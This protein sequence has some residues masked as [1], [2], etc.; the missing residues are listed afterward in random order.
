MLTKGVGHHGNSIQESS[1]WILHGTQEFKRAI[2]FSNILIW[3]SLKMFLVVAICGVLIGFASTA[4]I[5]EK[6]QLYKRGENGKPQGLE[7]VLRRIL[8]WF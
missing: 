1:N 4:P 7:A 8:K 2:N 3:L 5:R 6:M